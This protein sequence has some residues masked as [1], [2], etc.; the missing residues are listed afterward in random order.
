MANELTRQLQLTE[1]EILI[2]LDRVCKEENLTYFL[3]G[4]TLLGA[5]R[6]GGF[7]PW[8]DDIDVL[9]PREDYNRLIDVF[10]EGKLKGYH[11]Q[12][13]AVSYTH[14]RAHET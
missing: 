5:L 10:R 2:E 8:D 9:M 14:L 13:I 3:E 4:G 6:H 12:C 1:L 7:I 11:L